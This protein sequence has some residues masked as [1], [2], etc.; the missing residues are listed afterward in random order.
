MKK[1]KYILSVFAI[2][3]MMGSC[4]VY[5]TSVPQANVQTQLNVEMGDLEYIRDVTGT[6][7]QPFVLGLPY[8][9]TKYRRATVSNLSGVINIRNRGYNAALFNA[10][11][12]V[13]DADFVLPVSVEIISDR[14]FLGREDNITVR[15]KAFKLKVQ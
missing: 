8:G 15:V 10:L 13:P 4:T 2:L 14:M 7:T 9:G 12:S 1:L 3:M 5:H 11:E 6:A